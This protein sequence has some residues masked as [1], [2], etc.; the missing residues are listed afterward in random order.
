MNEP[1]RFAQ[2]APIKMLAEWEVQA[3][4]APGVL[5]DERQV[6]QLSVEPDVSGLAAWIAVTA[7]SGATGNA[8]HDAMR[9]K[10]RG[11]LTTC[12][13]RFGQPKIDEIKQELIRH[14]QQYR[15]R[16][17]ITDEEL[18]ARIERLFDAI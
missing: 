4:P 3:I 15:S 10:V 17:K 14:M 9:K 8:V 18:L 2:A 5:V 6:E 7:I 11:V 13:Q 16:R 12:R 1:N